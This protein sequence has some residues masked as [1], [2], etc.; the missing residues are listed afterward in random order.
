MQSYPPPQQSYPPPPPPQHPAAQM[1]GDAPPRARRPRSRSPEPE[2][3]RE[4]GGNGDERREPGQAR[5]RQRSAKWDDMGCG[6]SAAIAAATP[7]GA[8]PG[9]SFGAMPG[10]ML[11]AQYGVPVTMARLYPNQISMQAQ[12]SSKQQRTCYVGSLLPNV[13]TA[14]VL[15]EFFSQVFSSLPSYDPSQGPPITSINM[16][17]AGSFA[18]VEMRDEVLAATMMNLDKLELCGRMLKIGRPSGYVQTAFQSQPL[19]VSMLRI[20]AAPTPNALN[21]FITQQIAQGGY[22]QKG[23]DDGKQQR[24]LYVGNLAVGIVTG[25]MLHDL[26]QLPLQSMPGFDHSLG[27]A[28]VNV[29]MV[30]ESKFAFV[31][32]R[33]E[34]LATTAV[35]LLHGMELCGR[36]MHVGRPKGYVDPLG[37]PGYIPLPKTEMGVL[38]Q[39][40]FAPMPPAF[41]PRLP[42]GPAPTPFDPAAAAANRIADLLAQMSTA[43]LELENLVGDTNALKDKE[44]YDEIVGDIRSEC[45]KFG[46]V[47]ETRVPKPGNVE[48]AA[49]VGRAFVKF[50][51]T[52]ASTKARVALN[53]RQFDGNVVKATFVT[54]Q[55]YEAVPANE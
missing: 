39:G 47:L 8:Y 30:G 12:M 43:Y 6:P 14:E 28:V 9:G 40:V 13:V 55:A 33:S 32:I 34:E 18:F 25:P 19:D 24:V 2:R 4:Y 7:P 54:A 51:D 44:E 38:T 20:S 3:R 35:A 17:A 53:G 15:T 27:P 48:D 45:E 22:V 1:P 11:G 21:P 49:Y 26:F 52:A 37:G 36:K 29:N 16:G 42:D 46:V 23:P 10:G 5:R 50:A 41:V 31:E